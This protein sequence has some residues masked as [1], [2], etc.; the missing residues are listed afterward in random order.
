ML[1]L[2]PRPFLF[3]SN[4]RNKDWGDSCDREH[5]ELYLDFGLVLV[6]CS[7]EEVNIEEQALMSI[8]ASLENFHNVLENWDHDSV[9]PCSWT[10]VTCSPEN[11]VIGL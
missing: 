9:D 5:D 8:N 3:H 11:L 2:L 6:V 4:N 1:S 7:P 10:M